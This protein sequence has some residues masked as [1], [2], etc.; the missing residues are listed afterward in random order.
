MCLHLIKK[1][2]WSRAIVIGDNSEH[3]GVDVVSER[4]SSGV[5][6]NEDAE[7]SSHCG[8]SSSLI[9]HSV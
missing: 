9:N 1:G 7:A 5:I 6:G 2:M 8:S 4:S 3:M